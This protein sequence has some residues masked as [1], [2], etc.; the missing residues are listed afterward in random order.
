MDLLGGLMQKICVSVSSFLI[1]LCVLVHWDLPSPQLNLCFFVLLRSLKVG[2]VGKEAWVSQWPA[3]RGTFQ[4][5]HAFP[6]LLSLLI[7]VVLW[8]AQVI[9][10]LLMCTGLCV[11][12]YENCN[13]PNTQHSYLDLMLTGFEQAIAIEKKFWQCLG[14]NFVE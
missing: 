8:E 1:C 12:Y 4:P 2:N 11:W 3:G 10:Q 7:S 14:Q 13:I 5:H 6:P 9:A